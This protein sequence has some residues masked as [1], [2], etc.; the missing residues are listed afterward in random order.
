MQHL[1]LCSF[2]LDLVTVSYI[3]NIIF[4]YFSCIFFI[5]IIIIFI[6]FLTFFVRRHIL[7]FV[8]FESISLQSVLGFFCNIPYRTFSRNWKRFRTRTHTLHQK[9]VPPTHRPPTHWP[10]LTNLRWII[11]YIKYISYRLRLGKLPNS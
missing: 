7:R 4:L 8:L 1:T 10:A 9:H 5:I 3:F 11:V 2:F 6:L